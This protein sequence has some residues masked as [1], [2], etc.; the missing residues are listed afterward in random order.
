MEISDTR[1]ELYRI[2][3]E[4]YRK[5]ELWAMIYKF[6]LGTVNV[7]NEYQMKLDFQ[8]DLALILLDYKKPEKIIEM[9]KKNQLGY[10]IIMIVKNNLKSRNSPFWTKYNRYIQFK[11]DVDYKNLNDEYN[12]YQNKI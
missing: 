5:G 6:R 2:V 1:K 11:M 9:Y 8:Q 3:E 4:L 10:F 12:D 7:D